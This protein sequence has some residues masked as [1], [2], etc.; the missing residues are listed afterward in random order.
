MQR[1][2]PSV[3][4]I[5]IV[6]LSH[7]ILPGFGPLPSKLKVWLIEWTFGISGIGLVE[8][9]HLQQGGAHQGS[10]IQQ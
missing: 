8:P 10:P 2:W 1:L 5:Q 4:W 7:H 3:T 9:E 6:T